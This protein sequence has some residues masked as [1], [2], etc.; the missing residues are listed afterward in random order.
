MAAI[1]KFEIASTAF[2]LGRL[3]LDLPDIRMELDR[4]VPT[5]PAIIPYIWVMNASESDIEDVEA[6]ADEIREI[7]DIRRIDEVDGRYLI[8][9]KWASAYHGILAALTEMDGTLISG[10]GSAERWTFEVRSEDRATISAFQDRCRD[11]DI[12]VTLTSL[13]ELSSTQRDSEYGLTAPQRD[14]LVRAFERGYYESP[15]ETSLDALAEELGITG[16][17]FGARLRR[18]IHR[19]IGSTLVDRDQ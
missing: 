9:L 17:A 11:L 1:A 4:V 10:M 19:L 15:R 2:P 6:A 7:D 16:Q 14:A 8:N 5:Q 12:S 3:F 18:G 13:H